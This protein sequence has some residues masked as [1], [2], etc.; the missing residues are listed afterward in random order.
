MLNKPFIKTIVYGSILISVASLCQ[1]IITQ[2][3]FGIAFNYKS[4]SYQLFVFLS[5]FLQYNMQRGYSLIHNQYTSERYQWL[6]KNKKPMLIVM[7]ISLVALLFLCNW[8]SWTSILIM[9]SAELVSTLYY[10]KPFNLR[11]FGFIKPFLIGLIWVI[12]CAVV[13]LIEEN[14]LVENAWLFIIAQF[15]LISVLCIVFDIKDAVSDYQDGIKTYANT[16]GLNA[17]KLLAILISIVYYLLFFLFNKSL[18][19]SICNGFFLLLLII[20]ILVANEK[21]HS[22]Y[23]YILVDGLLIMQLIILLYKF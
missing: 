6:L 8:L 13:P 5:T 10:L 21:R 7:G 17:T 4:V 16:I 23:Y 1:V 22:F 11:R 3:I 2:K 14:L 9:I 18:I 19:L 12:T 15:L 20:S